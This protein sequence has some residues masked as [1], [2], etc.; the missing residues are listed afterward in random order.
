MAFLDQ[1]IIEQSVDT[2]I[3]MAHRLGIAVVAEG[4]EQVN[5]INLLEELNCDFAQGTY[6]SAAK[7]RESIGSFIEIYDIMG[8]ELEV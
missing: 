1:M 7:S 5:Q 3:L 4:V 6:F 8:R 2:I